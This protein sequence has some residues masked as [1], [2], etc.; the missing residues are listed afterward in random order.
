MTVW[1]TRGPKESLLHRAMI[2]FNKRTKPIYP[3]HRSVTEAFIFPIE[4]ERLTQHQYLTR[5]QR[6][7]YYFS[8]FFFNFFLTKRGIA[9]AIKSGIHTAIYELI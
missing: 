5:V 3:T 4:R 2:N 1:E 6:F 8:F 7:F 9:A